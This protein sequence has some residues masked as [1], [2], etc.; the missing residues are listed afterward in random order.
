MKKLVLSIIFTIIFVSTPTVY[1]D[2]S[3]PH[4]FECSSIDNTL[5]TFNSSNVFEGFFSCSG[6]PFS[7]SIHGADTYSIVECNPSLGDCTEEDYTTLISSE[8]YVDT[9]YY[10]W[11]EIPTG[12]CSNAEAICYQDWLI[13]NMIIIFLLSS[14]SMGLFI[15]FFKRSK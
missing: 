3:L 13:M 9:T 11:T 4:S 5:L 7:L 10:T 8:A 1:A 15:N 2:D 14:I 6:V 12:S